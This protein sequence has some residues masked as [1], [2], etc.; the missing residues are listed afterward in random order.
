MAQVGVFQ[1]AGLDHW[2]DVAGGKVD[3]QCKNHYAAT[4]RHFESYLARID[5]FSFL[6][7]SRASLRVGVQASI[8]SATPR[9]TARFQA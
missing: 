5:E 1:S 7:S 4:Q 9:L 8:S 3:Q 6:L 2:Q